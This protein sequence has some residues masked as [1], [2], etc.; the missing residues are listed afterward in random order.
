[1]HTVRIKKTPKQ[2]FSFSVTSVYFN[3]MLSAFL[4]THEVAYSQT[5]FIILSSEPLKLY[6]VRRV[7]FGNGNIFQSINNNDKSAIILIMLL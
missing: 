6:W 5:L 1:M 7:V 3:A 2:K 4:R